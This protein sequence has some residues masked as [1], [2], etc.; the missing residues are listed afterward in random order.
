MSFTVAIVHYHL[1]TGGVTRVIEH[2]CE[3]LKNEGIKTVVL[4]GETPAANLPA[5]T[6]VHVVPGLGYDETTQPD[7][8]DQLADRLQQTATAALGEAPSLWHVHNHALGK[9]CA[10]P[11]ALRLLAERGQ[12]LL[13]QFH[14]FAEDGRP[15]NYRRL[16]EYAGNGDQSQLGQALYPSADHIHYAA[17]NGRDRT[18]LAQ[19]GVDDDRLHLLANAVAIEGGEESNSDEDSKSGRLFL[20][21]T[22]AIR[23]K[24]L[25]EFLLW[26]ALGSTFDR[27][28]VT[29]APRN[30][31]QRPYYDRWVAFANKLNLPVTFELGMTSNEAYSALL[32]SAH[33]LVTTSVAEGFGLVFLEPWLANRPL[34]GR[35]LP[36]ITTEFSDAGINIENMYDRL[37]VP[38]DWIDANELRQRVEQSMNQSFD[39]YGQ[40][41]TND[42]ID[43]TI[44]DMI[45]NDRIDFGRLDEP[46]QET[47]IRH[48][49]DTPGAASEIDPAAL[50]TVGD[51]AVEKN[52]QT[53]IARF[54]RDAYGKTLTGIYQSVIAS[55]VSDVTGLDADALLRTFLAPSNFNLLRT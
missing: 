22:R 13:L 12:H 5:S 43:A 52:R 42:D 29:R 20:Y 35:N 18:F 31:Q 30:P 45:R 55:P 25:G 49:V 11:G 15:A 23:R 51:N 24:N 14:D 41:I 50:L 21:P 27:F 32:R 39:S 53:V 28:A 33:A 54:S 9:N 40:Q 2:A 16:L 10:L 48:V 6:E 17:L 7:Q 44:N 38:A 1:R 8:P 4:V 19:A 26:S 34:C 36:Q 47:V 37:D 46:L 3:A